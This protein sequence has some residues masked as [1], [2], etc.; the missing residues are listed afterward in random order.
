MADTRICCVEGCGKRHSS[1]GFCRTHYQR[2][3]R[4]G[5]PILKVAAP[6][7]KQ[8]FIEV[9]V[10][11]I[12]EECL[13]WPFPLPSG[14]YGTLKIKGKSFRAHVVVC[15]KAHGSKPSSTHQAA[16]SCGNRRCVNPKHLRWATPS[17]NSADKRI[18]GTMPEGERHPQSRLTAEQVRQIRKL[19]GAV[20]RSALA[21]H[22][23]VGKEHVTRIQSGHLWKNILP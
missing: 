7:S 23:G 11:H 12:S 22:F 8:R 20:S 16:H 14:G 15:E 17:E 18:H 6:K 4:H 13:E 2:W 5:A 9:A 1:K 10:S 3:Q 19:R 21:E